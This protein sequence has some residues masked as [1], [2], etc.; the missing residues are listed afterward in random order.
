[1]TATGDDVAR[2]AATANVIG[3]GTAITANATETITESARV[4]ESDPEVTN[5]TTARY[6]R[7]KTATTKSASATVTRSA[8][9]KSASDVIQ[10]WI[11]SGNC[12]PGTTVNPAACAIDHFD[13]IFFSYLVAFILHILLFRYPFLYVSLCPDPSSTSSSVETENKTLSYCHS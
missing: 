9:A 4:K 13:L 11:G 8:I 12:V 6:A 5:E 3:I 2:E 10:A 7:V 1:M